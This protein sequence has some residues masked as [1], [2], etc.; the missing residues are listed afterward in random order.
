VYLQARGLRAKHVLAVRGDPPADGLE[1]LPCQGTRVGSEGVR[2]FADTNVIGG[3]P[4]LL[5]GLNL[6][7]D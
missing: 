4:L 5:E 1:Y 6:Q 3:V 2:H 7:D